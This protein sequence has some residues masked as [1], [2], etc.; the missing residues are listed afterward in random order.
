[1]ICTCFRPSI[2]TLSLYISD[3]VGVGGSLCVE[4]PVEKNI[5]ISKSHVPGDKELKSKVC[6]HVKGE[7]ERPPS[8]RCSLMHL[9]RTV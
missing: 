8:I 2:Y 9:E 5:S 4:V 7:K 1:M 6:M 3:P